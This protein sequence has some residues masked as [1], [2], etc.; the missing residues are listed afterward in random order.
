MYTVNQIVWAKVEGYSWWPARIVEVMQQESGNEVLVNFLGDKSHAQLPFNKLAN[1]KERYDEFSKEK[2][3]DKRLWNAIEIAN[4]Y[5]DKATINEEKMTHKSQ[6]VQLSLKRKAERSLEEEVKSASEANPK[7]PNNPSPQITKKLKLSPTAPATTDKKHNENNNS[8]TNHNTNGVKPYDMSLLSNK[9]KEM[10]VKES[11]VFSSDVTGIVESIIDMQLSAVKHRIIE[12][13]LKTFLNPDADETVS[14]VG[15]LEQ[16]MSKSFAAMNKAK[17]EFEKAT[18]RCKEHQRR[19]MEMQAAFINNQLYNGV[20]LGLGNMVQKLTKNTEKQLPTAIKSE[21]PSYAFKLVAD[22][23]TISD[24]S[25][26]GLLVLRNDS[27]PDNRQKKSFLMS[28]SISP[29]KI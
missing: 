21:N 24:K 11:P 16:E 3:K 26:Q 17:E 20:G 29:I 10:T 4:A 14:F 12:K 9:I 1:Y 25:T 19:A 6:K 7:I 15:L 28:S 5:F 13:K 8:N 18:E 22:P 27:S 23:A 2:K